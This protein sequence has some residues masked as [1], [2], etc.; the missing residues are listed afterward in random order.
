MRR[1]CLMTDLELWLA[2]VSTYKNEAWGEYYLDAISVALI[3]A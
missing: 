1:A 3:R 2:R